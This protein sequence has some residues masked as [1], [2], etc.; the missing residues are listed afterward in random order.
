MNQDSS[1]SHSVFTIT[2]ESTAKGPD[3]SDHIRV[4]KLNLVDLAGSERQVSS[5][6]LLLLL[7]LRADGPC[8]VLVALQTKTGATGD[9]LKEGIKINLSLTALGNVI[10]ALVEGK[11][12]HVPYRDSKLTRLL[13]VCTFLACL[14]CPALHPT[15]SLAGAR[16]FADMACCAP[17]TGLA[18]RQHQDGDGGQHWPGG[19]EL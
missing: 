12:G 10:S 11:G 2:I 1:R 8:C 13:Q 4:G 5:C 6:L 14:R 17:W 19:L 3:G 9:R 16:S 7:L 15:A 18:G